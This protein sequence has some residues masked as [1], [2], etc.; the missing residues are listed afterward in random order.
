M[1]NLHNQFCP[2]KTTKQT[3]VEE[4]AT[5]VH[6]T[7]DG[8]LQYL[9]EHCCYCSLGDWLCLRLDQNFTGSHLAAK[10]PGDLDQSS[11]K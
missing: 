4:S 7:E 1:W 6:N 10:I 8:A 3:N 5:A 9:K 11:W 2:K